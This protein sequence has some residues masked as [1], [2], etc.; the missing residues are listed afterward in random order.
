MIYRRLGESDIEVSAVIF[1]AWAIGGWWWGDTDDELAIEAIR[2]AVDGGITTI[3]TA[4]MYG[5]GHSEEVVGRAVKGIADK[6][7]LATKCGL[8]WSRTDGEYFF[9]TPDPQGKTVPIYRVLKKDSIIAECEASLSRLGVDCI[10]LYQ[11]HWMDSTTALEETMEALVTLRDQGKI[12][13]IGLSNFTPEAIEQCAGY[14]P[15]AGHQPKFS[16]LDRQNLD[17]VISFTHSRGIGTIV[18]SPLEQGM[19]TGKVTMDREF[20]EGDYRAGQPWFRPANR[21]RVLDV[22]QTQID[23]IARAHGATLSQVA[24]AWTVGAPGITAAIVGARN[25]EQARANAAGADVPLTEP[26]REEILRAFEALG[27]P[28]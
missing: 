6:V 4:P 15:I 26:E 1:G 5:F 10:D 3:D 28:E 20:P 2:A 7:V 22:L 13:A 27:D 17:G 12:R 14:G 9:E 19:L 8:V 18:Y 23:P 21:R 24:I 25:G 11:C 16:L